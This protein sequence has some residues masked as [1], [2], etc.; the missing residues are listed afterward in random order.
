[1]CYVTVTQLSL[2]IFTTLPLC[3]DINIQNDIYVNFSARSSSKRYNFKK[4][5]FVDLYEAILNTDWSF[6]DIQTEVNSACHRFYEYLYNIFD[7]FVPLSRRNRL[8]IPSWYSKELCSNLIIKSRLFSKYK[9]CRTPESYNEFSL[10]R[11]FVQNLI[12]RDYNFYLANVERSILSDSTKFWNFIRDR[13]GRS[14]IPGIISYGQ[15]VFDNPQDI[16]DGFAEYF[17]SI[18]NKMVTEDINI[19]GDYSL[20]N[21]PVID[22]SSVNESEIVI[23]SKKLKP[24]LVSGLDQVP[25]LLVRDCAAIFTKPLSFIYLLNRLPFPTFGNMQESALYL[26]KVIYSMLQTTHLFPFCLTFQ[27]FLKLSFI[28]RSFLI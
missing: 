19:S 5:N 16:V 7:N 20:N 6:L 2:R 3:V 23:A 1:M 26:R 11:R 14:A 28:I 17:Y 15:R 24:N 9:R 27:S 18:Y 21:W 4:A 22:L 12:K 13:M 10:H 8:Y 25:S